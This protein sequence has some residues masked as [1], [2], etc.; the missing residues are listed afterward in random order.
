[1]TCLWSSDRLFTEG[2]EFLSKRIGVV[3]TTISEGKFLDAYLVAAKSHRGADAISVYVIGDVNTHQECRRRTEAARAQGLAAKY[4]DVAEQEDFLKP[5][6]DMAKLIPLRSDQRRNVGYL[7]ALRDRCDVLVSL[8]DDN[9]PIFDHPFFELHALAGSSQTLVATQSQNGWF[10]LGSLLEVADGAGRPCAVYPRGFP[11]SRRWSDASSVKGQCESG[12][13]AVSVGLWRG[14]P[15]VD[16]TTRLATACTSR[17]LVD[18]RYLLGRG[19]RSPINSQNTALIWHA[20][21]SYYFALMRQDVAGLQIDRFGDIFSGYFLQ[22]CAESVGH[23]VCVGSPWVHQDRNQHDLLQD[24]RAELPG[25]MLIEAMTGF[26]EDPLPASTSYCEAYLCLAERLLEWSQTQQGQVWTEST[27]RFYH[28]LH[29]AMRIWVETCVT[30][31][32]GE[33]ALRVQG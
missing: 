8:D 18:H 29:D 5:F 12:K 23:R 17:A 15:D 21:P 33:A 24:L 7:L 1:M 26:L 13:I 31:A 11:Y 25:M 22:M 20:I 30:L 16:A 6:P 14:D 27:R 2:N 28:S 19:Q 9:L 32:G 10:N 4:F 3:V